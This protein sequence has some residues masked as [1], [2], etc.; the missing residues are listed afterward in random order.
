[1]EA[2]VAAVRSRY[3]SMHSKAFPVLAVLLLILPVLPGETAENIS[4]EYMVDWSQSRISII[5][6]APIPSTRLNRA[7]A[8]Q[9]AIR[10]LDERM[11]QL[12]I[13]GIMHLRL[14]SGSTLADRQDGAR[15]LMQNIDEIYSNRIQEY[16]R[17]SSDL[18]SVQLRYHFQLY[19]YIISSFISH[20]IARPV[21]HRLG[22]APRAEYSGIIIYAALHE[23]HGAL[24]PKIR[25]ADG[26][27][28]YD[29]SMVP[30]EILR[31]RGAVRYF[32]DPGSTDISEH[33][34]NT[35]VRITAVGGFGDTLTDVE[36]AERDVHAILSNP[37]TRRA[38][39]EGRIA[40]I[41]SPE[42]GITRY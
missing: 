42:T 18:Q 28:V 17:V 39:Q 2:M 16:S 11:L 33:V 31:T 1:M 14:D 20:D 29:H 15:S 6:E 7:S 23:I 36:L 41:L 38:M 10:N 25:S 3:Y 30:P 40:I 24:L 22:W 32:T 8:R 9:Q 19:P 26:T 12:L 34:G 4:V 35:P 27:I 13:E 5:A 37:S 21:P